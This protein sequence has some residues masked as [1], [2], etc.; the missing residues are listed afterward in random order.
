MKKK[1]REETRHTTLTAYPRA[2]TINGCQPPSL[3]RD[4]AE[5]A[6]RE[7][8]VGLSG[9]RL[10]SG[11]RRRAQGS[12]RGARRSPS[13]ETSRDEQLTHFKILTLNTSEAGRFLKEY[14]IS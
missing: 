2:S 12:M 8:H 6:N 7:G 13:L 11:R 5:G 1:S 14:G 9:R 10:L 3:H 4:A